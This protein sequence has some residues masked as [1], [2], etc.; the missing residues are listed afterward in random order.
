[1][2]IPKWYTFV[3]NF[4][5]WHFVDKP[6]LHQRSSKCHISVT[7]KPHLLILSPLIWLITTICGKHKRII[8]S[9]KLAGQNPYSKWVNFFFIHPVNHCSAIRMRILTEFGP[10]WTET[11]IFL[12]LC[13]FVFIYFY[14]FFIESNKLQWLALLSK[15]AL[16][17][18]PYKY[19]CTHCR[20]IQFIYKTKQG[21][22]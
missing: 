12:N 11:A 8:E 14:A 15:K 5:L 1:M 10:E 6:I 21:N 7:M 3:S 9:K 17:F 20:C 18:K 22:N 13:I 2:S 16:I 19:T 4:K